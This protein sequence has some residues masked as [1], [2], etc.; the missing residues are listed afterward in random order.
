MQIDD[1]QDVSIKIPMSSELRGRWEKFTYDRG[2]SRGP[3]LRSIVEAI[4]DPVK[5]P[6]IEALTRQ[7]VPEPVSAEAQP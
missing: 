2:Y 1:T 4:T 5:G 3:F 7:P 6:Q